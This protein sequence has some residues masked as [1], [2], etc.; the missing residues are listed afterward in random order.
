[1]LFGPFC[2]FLCTF[3]GDNDNHDNFVIECVTMVLSSSSTT[4][5]FASH[6]KITYLIR[7]RYSFNVSIVDILTHQL[8]YNAKM[9]IIVIIY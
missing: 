7:L 9:M 2:I 3:E 4:S 1:M 6:L 5:Q 8:K